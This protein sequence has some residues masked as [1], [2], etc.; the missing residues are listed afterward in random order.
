MEYTGKWWSVN[1]AEYGPVNILEYKSDSKFPYCDCSRCGQ[2]IKKHMFVV[3]CAEEGPELDVEM[4]YLGSECI[5][6]LR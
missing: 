6:H 5:K 3:Q 4:A 2:P 1:S